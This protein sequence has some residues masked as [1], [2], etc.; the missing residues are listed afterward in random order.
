MAGRYLYNSIVVSPEPRGRF[1]QGP[2]SGALRPGVVVQIKIATEKVSGNFSFE[3]FNTGGDGRRPFG[4]ILVLCEDRLQGKTINDA[5]A[6]GD[7]ATVYCPLPG[8]ELL[9]MLG[10]VAG[11]DTD[12]H[13][14]GDPYM[15]DED[16][17]ELIAPSSEECQ[18]FVCLETISTGL[19]ADTLAH[20]MFSGY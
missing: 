2:V 12:T 3:V 14:I 16:T 1:F 8:D 17:G 4:P 18:P 7:L 5:Y 9:M 20:V 10:D 15:V 13:A 6:S 11:T 19:D